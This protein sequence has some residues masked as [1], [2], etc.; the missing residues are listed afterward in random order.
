MRPLA[1]IKRAR[2]FSS[3]FDDPAAGAPAGDAKLVFD[4]LSAGADVG[5]EPVVADELPGSLVVVALVEAEALR[6]L[7]SR[8][9]PRYRD[10]VEGTLEEQVVVAVGPGMGEADGYPGALGENRAFRPLF[11]LS[12]GLGPVLG[13]PRGALVM[14]PSQERK[15]QSTPTSSS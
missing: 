9:R 3:F 8:L 7:G 15:L 10:G 4:L 11:A 6:L 12:V 2:W 14:A 5:D 13:P 1:N